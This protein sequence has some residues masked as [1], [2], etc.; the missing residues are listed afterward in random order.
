MTP[1]WAAG[2][3]GILRSRPPEATVPKWK[4]RALMD[5]F[6]RRAKWARERESERFFNE[7][8]RQKRS[9]ESDKSGEQQI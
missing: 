6:G 3:A 9:R 7:L 4:I 8:A 2:A 5:L 1:G